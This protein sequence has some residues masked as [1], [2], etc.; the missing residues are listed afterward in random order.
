MLLAATTLVL[1]STTARAQE[2]DTA[3][4]T[5]RSMYG[6]KHKGRIDP[7]LKPLRGQL[8]KPPFASYRTIKLLESKGHK[9]PHNGTIRTKLPTKKVLMLTFK[10]K[11]LVKRQ[12]RLRMHLSITPPRAVGFLPGTLFTI[13]DGGTLL[14]AGDRYQDG[15][16]IVG[17]TCASN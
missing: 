7:A 14:V 8:S 5:I 12:V 3:S 11:L 15:T 9:I 16:L 10:E 6:S 2:R 1:S 4:C 13:A 17:V